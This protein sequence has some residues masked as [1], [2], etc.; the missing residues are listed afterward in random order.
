MKPPK[1][2]LSSTISFTQKYQQNDFRQLNL[3]SFVCIFILFVSFS[4]KFRNKSQ[5]SPDIHWPQ[6]CFSFHWPTLPMVLA[7]GQQSPGQ[8]D[9]PV[10]QHV[11]NNPDYFEINI[12]SHSW[13]LEHVCRLPDVNQS[14]PRHCGLI[15]DQHA[16]NDLNKV[17][18][19]YDQ[20]LTTN[21]E[22]EIVAFTHQ[23]Q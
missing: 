13:S 15:L 2:S 20:D 14:G 1:Y 9:H 11:R 12:R 3:L 17:R 4:R 6:R 18:G 21:I 5:Y 8:A 19:W 10:R 16:I 7:E 23:N 22:D